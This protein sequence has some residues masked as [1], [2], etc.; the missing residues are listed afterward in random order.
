MSERIARHG[1]QKPRTALNP[2]SAYS[3]GED[4][5]LLVAHYGYDLDPW[6]KDVLAA[7]VA[8]DEADMYA[9]TSCGLAVPRQNGK[10]ALLEARELYGIVTAGEKFLHTAHEV[11]TARKAFLR[12]AG[13]FENDREYPEL[14]AMVKCIRRTNGQ[15]A[16]ELVNGGSVE[17]SA[18]SRGAARG[19]TVDTVV[20]DEAQ[21]LTDEQLEAM[22]PTLAA[23]P[24]GCRQFIYTGTPPGPNSPG[25]VFRRTRMN[26]L[27]GTLKHGSWHEW[28]VESLPPQKSAF[29]DVRELCYQT[30]P[31][32]GYRIDIDFCED[33]FG[34]M[35][36]DGFA[37]ERLGWWSETATAAVIPWPQWERSG[38]DA[39]AAPTDGKKAFGVKFAPDGH[40]VSLAVCLLPEDGPAHVELL[41]ARPLAGGVKWLAD[42]LCGDKAR[43]T[44]AAIIVDGRNGAAPLLAALRG[45]YPRQAVIESNGGHMVAACSMLADALGAGEVTHWAAKEQEALDYSVK[46]STRRRIGNDGGWGFDGPESEHIEAVALALYAAKTTRRHPTGRSMIL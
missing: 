34:S 10:N 25:T 22:L 14:N 31:A 30:N 19:Y 24:S 35:S 39:G 36:L 42:A 29:E 46:T 4:A 12:L 1:A 44:T 40:V 7:W 16:I 21:E 23:A 37:R 2:P 9:A 15:E 5:A 8:R 38:I 18:R 33:E 41:G 11:K 27:A 32:L 43:R 45:R 26:A 20:F 28:S 17:F 13:F 3:D 6:Q